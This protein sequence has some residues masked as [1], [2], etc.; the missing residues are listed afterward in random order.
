MSDVCCTWLVVAAFGWLVSSEKVAGGLLL[1]A[2]E[3]LNL[4]TVA[5]VNHELW[6]LLAHLS[7]VELEHVVELVP[8]L[9][10]SWGSSGVSPLDLVHAEALEHAAGSLISLI[11]LHV[12]ELAL[13][14]Q[15]EQVEGWGAGQTNELIEESGITLRDGT[16]S[17]SLVKG[18]LEGVLTVVL[19]DSA[20]MWLGGDLLWELMWEHH[21]VLLDD[22]WGHLGESLILSSE[23]SL[24]L[25][26]A[27][28]HAEEELLVLVGVSEREE[29]AL[30]LLSI[31]SLSEVTLLLEPG[32][33][34]HLVVEETSTMASEEL[35]ESEELEWVW[36]LTPVVV[37]LG[38]HLSLKIVESVVPSLTRVGID[39]PAL[40]VLGLSPVWDGE[41]LEDGPWAT[42]EGDI[43][44][45]LED[46]VWVEVLRIDME[47]HVWL[48]VE[49]VVISVLHAHA[50][51]IIN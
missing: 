26:S 11:G 51:I 23:L 17:D 32:E 4:G 24:S 9:L 49:L 39:L 50:Y 2:E 8:E 46:G 35:L 21:L 36:L 5:V 6:E 16:A 20:E 18:S 3:S 15:D 48:L 22:L 38:G 43:P 14:D 41:T 10:L 1:S 37:W 28:V 44:D 47:K 29:S 27:G 45:T 33:L 25:W 19:P 31:V 34:W 7:L 12:A 40:L 42:V 13:A 30:L